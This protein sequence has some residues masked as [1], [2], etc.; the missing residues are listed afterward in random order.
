MLQFTTCSASAGPFLQCPT[1]STS[2]LTVEKVAGGPPAFA[3]PAGSMA[4]A[5]NRLTNTTRSFFSPTTRNP[6]PWFANGIAQKSAAEVRPAMAAEPYGVMS[7]HEMLRTRYTAQ[8]ECCNL[9]IRGG[10]RKIAHEFSA[11]SYRPI[12]VLNLAES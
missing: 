1:P 9:V 10:S 11:T 4:S 3:D 5:K 2:V 12:G 8:L 7:H 6:L